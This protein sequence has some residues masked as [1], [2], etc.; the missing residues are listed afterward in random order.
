MAR[1]SPS[2][3]PMRSKKSGKKT[4]KRLKLNNEVLKKFK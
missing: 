2:P 1:K 4:A 3:V